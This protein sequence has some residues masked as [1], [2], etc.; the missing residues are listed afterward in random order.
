MH[1]RPTA[2]LDLNLSSFLALTMTDL[3][4][5]RD[6]EPPMGDTAGRQPLGDCRALWTA[7]LPGE[8]EGDHPAPARRIIHQRVLQLHAPARLS[9]LGLRLAQGY[10][11]CGSTTDRDWVTSF[12]LR[13]WDGEAWRTHLEESGLPRPEPGETLWFDLGGIEAT[14]ALV[15]V[16]RCGVD[17]WWPSWNLA[18][19]ALVLE[20]EMLGTIAP[21]CETLLDVTEVALAGLPEGLVAKHEHGEVR[22]RSAHLDVGFCLNRAGFSHLSIDELGGLLAP[23][24]VSENLL[25]HGPGRFYQGPMLAPLDGPPV[26]ATALRNR[27]RGT[28]RVHGNRVTYTL[29]LGDTG[30]HLRLAWEVLPDR[31]VLRAERTA[32]TPMRAW[33][34]SAWSLGLHSVAMPA[35][36]IGETERSGQT[37]RLTLPAWLHTPRFGSLLIESKGE[38]ET[39]ALRSD[40]VRPND[41]TT[42]DLLLGAEPQPEGDYLLPAGRHSATLTFCLARPDVPLAPDT[43]RA[44]R[45]AIDRCALTALTYRADTATL[46]NNGASMHCPICMDTWAA[47]AS[48]LGCVLPHL[49]AMVLVRDSLERWLDGGQGYTSGRLRVGGVFHEAEDEYV[50][51]G[52]ACLLG[53]ADYLAHAGTPEWL[54]RYAA[55]IASQIAKM[56]ARDLDGDGLVESPYRTGTSGSGQ[57]STC[58][59]DVVSY[60]WKDAFSNALLYPALVRLAELFPDLDQPDLAEGLADWAALLRKN[61]V[62]TFYNDATGWL[63]GWRCKDDRLH[64]HAF[65]APNGAAIVGGL[66]DDDMALEV[67]QRLWAEAQRVGMPDPYLGLPGNLRPIPDEDLADI[68]QGYPLGFYQNGGRTHSQSRHFV[69]A[70]YRVGM[71]RE[72]DYLLSR[73]AAGLADGAV[74]GGS[75]SGLDWRYWDGRPCGYEGLL[76]DQFGILGVMLE[77]YGA[78]AE[79]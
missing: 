3:F 23:N 78:N 26:A 38:G 19:G 70:L 29:T 16:R 71:T 46:T 76:T 66:L 27:A 8:M 57:W 53:L 35:H 41:L 51:T 39:A 58:W 9:R 7:P 21:R 65:L 62:P 31:L 34:A 11:K 18:T 52:T 44:I 68:M 14:S 56:R 69:G 47:T 32:D 79:L 54:A 67:M 61:Y 48:R 45:R 17:A 12:R 4:A 36:A 72:A 55:P 43:P 42:L 1:G 40:A 73:L 20:G 30:Q 22:Y 5:L 77:R 24:A 50:M 25:R 60:G 49:D 13:V 28:T 33:Q 63:A 6:H 37:G 10:H 15:E 75:R 64:D 74:F 2:L 59:F